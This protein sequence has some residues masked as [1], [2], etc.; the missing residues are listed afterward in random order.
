MLIRARR[1]MANHK[2]WHRPDA[3]TTEGSTVIL[4][5]VCRMKGLELH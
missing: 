4:I 2:L 3:H 1:C 5:R